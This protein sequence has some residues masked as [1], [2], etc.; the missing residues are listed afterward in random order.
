M[1][2]ATKIASILNVNPSPEES[3]LRY[4]D[5]PEAITAWQGSGED[6]AATPQSAASTVDLST[7]EILRQRIWWWADLGGFDRCCRGI[8]LGLIGGDVAAS[9]SRVMRYAE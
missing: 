4:T 8:D 7:S 6:R 9:G 1:M 2:K 3:D 5:S